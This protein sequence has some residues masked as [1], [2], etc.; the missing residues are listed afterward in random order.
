MEKVDELFSGTR[1]QGGEQSC[2]SG[3]RGGDRSEAATNVQVGHVERDTLRE[4]R[5]CMVVGYVGGAKAVLRWLT[6]MWVL[7]VGRKKGQVH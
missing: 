3:V 5:D 1:G 2:E 7:L 4:R 6:M